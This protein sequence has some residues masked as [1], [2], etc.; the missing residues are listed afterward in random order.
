MYI[1][2]LQLCYNLN[3]PYSVLLSDIFTTTVAKLQGMLKP[4]KTYR[5]SY[6]TKPSMSFRYR[7]KQIGYILMSPATKRLHS[8]STGTKATISVPLYSNPHT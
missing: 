8:P 7:V 4:Y 3:I 5:V 1:Y 2:H 6:M